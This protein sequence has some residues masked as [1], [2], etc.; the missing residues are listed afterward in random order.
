MMG[1]AADDEKGT[2]MIKK[3]AWTPEEDKKLVDHIQ[4]HGHGSWRALPKLAGLKRCGKSCRLRWTNY[5]RPDVKRGKF[6]QE[7][8]HSIINLHALLGN[9]WSTIAGHLPGRTDNEIKNFWNTHLKKKLVKMGI[10]PVT[11][12]PLTTHHQYDHNNIL[13]NLLLQPQSTLINADAA[14]A[15]VANLL[16]PIW[17]FNNAL[18]LSYCPSSDASVQQIANN[19]QA[20]HDLV[21]VLFGSTASPIP[22]PPTTSSS[23]TPNMANISVGTNISTHQLYFHTNINPNAEASQPTP[24]SYDYNHH[25]PISGYKFST[26]T[27]IGTAS[28]SNGAIPNFNDLDQLPHLVPASYTKEINASTCTD[29][30]DDDDHHHHHHHE[31]EISKKINISPNIHISNPSSTSTTFEVLGWRDLID[32]EATDSYWKDIME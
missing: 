24:T 2:L 28:T 6:S 3:G 11:H 21:Q 12:R 19:I 22:S 16:N 23:S 25:P 13:S 8:E 14:A 15:N 5:L 7:E 31:K 18:R 27:S 1:R 29:I 10:D 30:G 26:N 9:K 4:K 32:D 17:E 20:L